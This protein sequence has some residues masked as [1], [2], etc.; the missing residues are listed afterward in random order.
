[1]LDLVGSSHKARVILIDQDHPILTLT[2]QSQLLNIARTSLYT[3]P[4]VSPDTLLL[5]QALDHLHTDYPF[6]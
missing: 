2:R 4:V 5:M 1:M 3:V 6:L